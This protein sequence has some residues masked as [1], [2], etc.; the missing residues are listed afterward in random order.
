MYCEAKIRP[1]VSRLAPRTRSAGLK[2]LEARTVDAKQF[3]L[4]VNAH[5]LNKLPKICLIILV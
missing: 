1:E 4:H 3:R 2:N 5:Q